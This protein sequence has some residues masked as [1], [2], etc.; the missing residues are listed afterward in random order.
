M[1]PTPRGVQPEIRRLPVAIDS[2]IQQVEK[3][4]KA[5][6]DMADVVVVALTKLICAT[7]PLLYTQRFTCA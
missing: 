1:H 5:L 7:S 4:E 3:N 6:Q 2:L